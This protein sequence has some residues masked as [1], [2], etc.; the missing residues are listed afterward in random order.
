M[1]AIL[2]ALMV[3]LGMAGLAPSA[4]RAQNSNSGTVI[5]QITDA[6]G[7]AMVGAVI[8]LT[9]TA[10]NGAQATIANSAGRYAFVNLQPGSYA[11]DVKKE[12]FKEAVVKNQPITVGKTLTVNVPMQVGT[13]TQT[14]EVTATGAELQTMNSTVG[15]SISGDAI[16]K[17]PNLNRDANS[18]TMLQPNTAP[19]GGIAGAASDQNSFTLDG[20]SN[21]N[22]MDGNN[23]IYTP[24]TGGQTSG[25][26]PTPAES[27][28]QFSV[29]VS[30][31]TADVNSAAGSSVAMVTRRGTPTVHGSVY[32]YYL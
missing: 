1:E 25:V 28:E 20:G 3:I 31:Q 13:A 9:N 4:A 18:L 29:G 12:G 27:I 23:S 10:T 11:L 32:E 30:N 5:G 24:A 6:Q 15:S 26:M 22:D 16:V 21:S 8:T 2:V 7:A 17:L 19:N 14:V